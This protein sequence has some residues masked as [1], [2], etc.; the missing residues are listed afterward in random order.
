MAAG[1][2]FSLAL[3]IAPDHRAAATGLHRAEVLDQVMD[4]LD[5]GRRRERAG[6]L[7]QA[8]EAYRRA[9]ALDPFSPPAQEALARVQARFGDNAFAAFMSAGLKALSRGDH[10]A[11]KEAFRRAGEIKPG[12]PEAADGLA[13][14]EEAE[15]LE[16]IAVQR[17]RATSREGEERWDEAA[18][19]YA[20][21]LALP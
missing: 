8:A 17:A 10:A 5:Q 9:T 11:A 6:E 19:A 15:R 3:R 20:A 2:A 4:L 21:V 7:E 13:Q 12:S 18:A 16:A 14:A 1:A